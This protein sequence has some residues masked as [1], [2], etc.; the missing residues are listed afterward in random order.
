LSLEP[1]V[2]EIGTLPPGE[3]IF[4]GGRG[5]L[6]D[7]KRDIIHADPRGYISVSYVEQ[8]ARDLLN[9]AKFDDLQAL[10]E[11]VE[12]LRIEAAKYRELK[13][14]LEGVVA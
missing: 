3:C 7:T 5:P 4:T 2:V 9:M 8:L 1:E 6:I 14:Q 10:I 13:A 12:D 11:E